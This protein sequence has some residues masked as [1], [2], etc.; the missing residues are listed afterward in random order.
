[1]LT[2]E[3]IEFT[4]FM[5]EINL[6][7]QFATKDFLLRLGALLNSKDI[8]EIVKNRLLALIQVIY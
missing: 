6:H 2:L 4:T 3:L 7:N 5:C 1:M 8:E